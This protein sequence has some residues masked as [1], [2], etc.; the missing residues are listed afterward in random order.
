M[1]ASIARRVLLVDSRS[2]ASR[3][4]GL[5]APGSAATAAATSRS[6][7]L[8]P[9]FVARALLATEIAFASNTTGSR[10]DW[11]HTTGMSDEDTK[12]ILR[13]VQRWLGGLG[14][15]FGTRYQAP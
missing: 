12:V 8:H 4:A 11:I 10:L 3:T 5:D 2:K 1:Y 15:A 6:A 13:S 9:R 7:T 14:G